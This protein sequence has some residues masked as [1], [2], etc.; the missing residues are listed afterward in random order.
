MNSTRNRHILI[1]DDNAA[2]HEDFRKILDISDSDNA[3]AAAEADIFGDTQALI[4]VESYILDSAYQGMEALEKVR[5]SVKAGNPY[6][7]AFVDVRM[8][9]GWD[10]I[11]T[12]EHIWREYPDLQ[13]VICT[14]YSDYSWDEMRQQLGNSDRLLILKKPFDAVE[15]VQMAQALTE[16]WHLLQQSRNRMTDLERMVAERTHGL[17]SANRKLREEILV[18]ERAE[19]DA[20][21]ARELAEEAQR[22]IASI[23][24]QLEQALDRANQMALEAQ[25]SD[26]AKSAFLANMS[27]EIRTPMNGDHWHVES[28]AGHC[29]NRRSTRLRRHCAGER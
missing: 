10:G 23:N 4:P 21:Q 24:E 25:T 26:C 15:V 19:I 20:R 6:A 16:K 3:M 22:E 9:P 8:P 7:L 28:A 12:V 14:A 13:V 27:H 29:L 17:E 1:I 5:Q 2:I 11:E 18:R